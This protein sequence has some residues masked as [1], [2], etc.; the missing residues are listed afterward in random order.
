MNTLTRELI[1]L[2]GKEGLRAER[3]FDLM[4]DDVLAGF[5]LR[6]APE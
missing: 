1:G 4:L 6:L 5:G 3:W 2:H